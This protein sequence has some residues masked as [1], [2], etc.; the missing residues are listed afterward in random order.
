MSRVRR[1]LV[2]GVMFG[3]ASVAGSV[4]MAQQP[5][6]V[7]LPGGVYNQP[8]LAYALNDLNLRSGGGTQYA[9]IAVMPRGAEVVVFDCVG[10]S[11][12]NVEWQGIVGWA[13]ATYLAPAGPQ[14][15]VTP[16]R[17]RLFPLFG[18]RP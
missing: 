11:W 12:C 16:P 13:S 8:I 15:V 5:P 10:T 6:A 14:T 4:A 17:R 2:T 18:P 9:V 3:A 1:L 7:V